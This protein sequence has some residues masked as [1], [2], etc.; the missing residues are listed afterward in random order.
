MKKVLFTLAAILGLSLALVATS[1]GGGGGS[2]D[3]DARP[4]AEVETVGF[5]PVPGATFDGTT[6]ITGSYV[7]IEG[8][9]INIPSLW[10]CDHEVTQ[11]EYQSVMGSNPSYFSS[12]PASGETQANRPV[13][14]VSWYDC[15]VYCNKRSL[16]A[17]LTPCYTISGKTNPDEWGSVPTARNETWNSATCDWTANGYRLPTEAEWEYLARGGNL[18]NNGQTEYSGSNTI[19]DVA[20]SS[21]NSGDMTHEVKKKAANALGVYDMSG[22]VWEWCWDWYD[23]IDTS[24]PSTGAGASSCVC[25]VE[26]GSCFDN[27]VLNSM[28]FEHTVFY[29][30][31]NDPYCRT[32]NFCSGFRVVRSRSE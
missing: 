26:R 19:G 3:D 11:A 6:G 7:F 28:V 18:T 23:P 22:N 10:A 29:R 17:N 31:Y 2:S 1:C 9:T 27:G 30:D 21:E 4:V 24:T 25:R 5:V 20:W 13:D 32:G 16:A 8:R 14:S 15:L 12:S